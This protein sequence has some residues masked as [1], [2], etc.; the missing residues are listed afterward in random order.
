[1]VQRASSSIAAYQLRD[2]F[3]CTVRRHAA[4]GIMPSVELCSIAAYQ[5]RDTG[6]VYTLRSRSIT[7]SSS[8]ANYQLRDSGFVYTLRSRSITTV[9]CNDNQLRDSIICFT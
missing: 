8:I 6:F 1:V 9:L 7:R 2:R 4:A 5:L 3:A